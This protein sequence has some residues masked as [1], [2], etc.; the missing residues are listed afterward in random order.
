MDLV[1]KFLSETLGFTDIYLYMDDPIAQALGT[2]N[3]EKIMRLGEALL[4]VST[5]PIEIRAQG[6][7]ATGTFL[8]QMGY[9]YAK[10]AL[11]A[12]CGNIK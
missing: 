3:D 7:K 5:I 10:E 6:L 1:K 9:D 4:E 2:V 11:L 12:A 8:A